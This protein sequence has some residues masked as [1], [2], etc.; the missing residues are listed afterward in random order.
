MSLLACNSVVLKEAAFHAYF[1]HGQ[2]SKHLLHDASSLYITAR[3]LAEAA[4][5]YSLGTCQMT[6]T[7]LLVME[8]QK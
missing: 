2:D 1:R 3:S 6:S 4:S 7:L 8:K 5:V